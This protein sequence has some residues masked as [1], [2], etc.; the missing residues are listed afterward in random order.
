MAKEK[1]KLMSVTMVS[2]Q[3]GITR[4]RVLQLI[5]S[6]LLDAERAGDAWVIRPKAFERWKI[7]RRGA[8]RPPTK[9]GKQ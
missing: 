1:E 8:G 3:G 2:E 4:Q 6:G 9:K 5:K 7:S